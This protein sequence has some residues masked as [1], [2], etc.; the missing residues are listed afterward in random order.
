MKTAL[1][2]LFAVLFAAGLGLGAMPHN[3]MLTLAPSSP[4]SPE[5]S[6][7]TWLGVAVGDISSSLAKQENLKK[8]EG[9]YVQK[10]VK[11]SPAD[12]AGIKKGDVIVEFN[13]KKISEADDLAR[14]V[15]KTEPGEKAKVT[16]YRGGDKKELSV[17]LRKQ[18]RRTMSFSF[19]PR[20]I[21][22]RVVVFRNR[23]TVGLNIMPLNPQ[24][25]KYFE[26]PD[27]KGVLV[28]S[29]Q[30]ASAAEKAGFK[31]GDV[32]TKIEDE[33]ID[34]VGDVREALEDHE[35]GDKVKFDILRK[36]SRQSLTVEVEENEEGHGYRFESGDT[37]PPDEFDEDFPGMEDFEQIQLHRHSIQ[38]HFD[39]FRIVMKELG[40]RLEKKNKIMMKKLEKNLQKLDGCCE[41]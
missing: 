8:D 35:A 9:A 18:K 4:E 10:V 31:A 25:A 11:N 3:P 36:G 1:V 15:R 21:S 19:A 7:G 38:P 40:E 17:A 32:L 27:G 26:A 39:R 14:A 12:S 6:D 22:R 30:E 34:D 28:T 20:N 29:V 33:S 13:G 16:L 23:S 37:D 5:P 2:P 41:L 24:L